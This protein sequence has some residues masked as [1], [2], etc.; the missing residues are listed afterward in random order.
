MSL[1]PTGQSLLCQIEYP[2]SSTAL[3]TGHRRLPTKQS[4]LHIRYMP[5]GKLPARKGHVVNVHPKRYLMNKNIA[6]VRVPWTNPIWLC[7]G[8]SQQ[9]RVLLCCRHWCLMGFQ[10][11]LRSVLASG[12]VPRHSLPN[13]AML[14]GAWGLDLTPWMLNL[15][16]G[17]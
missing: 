12:Q 15:Q 11:N 2:S 5:L 17:A 3:V 10:T 6:Y 8:N 1:R 14:C 4:L 9:V 7:G 13:V 16:P